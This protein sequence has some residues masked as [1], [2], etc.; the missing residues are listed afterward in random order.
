MTFPRKIGILMIL[1]AALASLGE[2]M[3]W[4]LPSLRWFFSF[5]ADPNAAGEG[6]WFDHRGAIIGYLFCVVLAIGGIVAIV[7]GRSFHW[8]PLTL[9]KWQRFQSIG[10]GY[11]SFRLLMFF[12]F[13]ALLDQAL[14][15]KRALAVRHQGEWSF[16]AFVE[17]RY[18]GEDFGREGEEEMDY[19]LLKEESVGTDTLVILPPVPWDPTF[20]SDEFMERTLP[21][22]DGLIHAADSRE[23]FN[24]FAY[25]YR[26]DDPETLLRKVRV[27]DGRPMG[28]AEVMGEDGEAVGREIW[29]E[30]VVVDS[31]LPEGFQVPATGRWVERIYMPLPPTMERRHYLGTDSKGWDIVAQLYGGLQVA[32]KGAMLYVALT[33][34]IG[35]TMG[36]LMGYFGGVY[37]IVMQRVMEIMSNVPFLLVVMIITNNIG[38]DNISLGTILLVFCLFSWIS[39][40]I[41]L[42]TATYKEKARDY[43][44]A[45]RVL[46]AG[47]ARVIFRHI[48]PN[49]ISTIV[50]LIPFSFSAVVTGL[51]AL[52]FLGFG[53]PDSYPSWGRM[54]NDGVSNLES[55]WIVSSAFAGMVTLLLLITFVGEAIREAFDPKK[56]TTYQ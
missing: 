28:S 41:Y 43:A 44:S 22:I 40:A 47:T 3:A 38:R 5:D 25:N 17:K 32:F 56:F 52:D 24:G 10:R 8:N 33:Y 53:V 50:T 15:G 45:A 1:I 4:S 34:F 12:V 54:L 2:V 26:E 35:I 48:L 14:V 30:G 29:N 31:N 55:P 39:V 9:R 7:R 49:A 16:P 11:T 36:S 13:L 20:D 6:P 21:M 46:G 37:D 19:R 42:R 23:T 27:R 51:T 18:T